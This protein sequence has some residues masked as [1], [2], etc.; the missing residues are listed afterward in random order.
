MSLKIVGVGIFNQVSTDQPL[1]NKHRGIVIIIS[2]GPK[3]AFGK[4]FITIVV[5]HCRTSFYAVQKAQYSRIEAADFQEVD[6][7]FPQSLQDSY[8]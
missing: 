7:T 8:Q 4:P 6:V 5:S 2:S 1:F 3:K